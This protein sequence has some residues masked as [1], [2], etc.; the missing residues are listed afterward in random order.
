M[1]SIIRLFIFGYLLS[2]CASINLSYLDL[3]YE[4]L[5]NENID[6]EY[7]DNIEF[8]SAEVIYNGAAYLFVLSSISRGIESW[9]GPNKE[10]IRIHDGII[11]DTFGFK[12]NYTLRLSNKTSRK[13]DLN[14]LNGWISLSNPDLTMSKVIFTKLSE[15]SNQEC[16]RVVKYKRSMPDILKDD[17]VEICYNSELINYTVQKTDPLSESISIKFN[18][19]F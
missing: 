8:S 12:N 19:K 18:Y 17:L 9:V 6:Q 15:E 2:S 4:S 3:F 10:L 5:T 11:L 16:S 1:I 13:P 7:V 14:I